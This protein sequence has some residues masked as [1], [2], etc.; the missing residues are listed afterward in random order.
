MSY[1]FK[2][3]TYEYSFK[4]INIQYESGYK[5]ISGKNS[6]SKI[7]LKKLKKIKENLYSLHSRINQ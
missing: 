1:T 2:R 4:N 5:R 3:Q 6:T 7:T